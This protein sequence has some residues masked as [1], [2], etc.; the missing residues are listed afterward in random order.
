MSLRLR[1]RWN[2]QG[3]E[4]WDWEVFLDDEGTGE[5]DQVDYVEY[6]LHPT[7]SKPLVRIDNPDGG[8]VLR[9]NGWGTFTLTAFAIKKDGS[10]EK[11]THE[12]ELSYDPPQ[13]ISGVHAM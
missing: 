6:V 1:N 8:F 2:Y 13:G 11:L 7:F 4:R 10:R 12:L 9:T 3:E 5:L